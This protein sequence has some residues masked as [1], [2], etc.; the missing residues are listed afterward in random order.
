M[1]K[2]VC[3]KWSKR[4][5]WFVIIATLLISDYIAL[6]VGTGTTYIDNVCVLIWSISMLMMLIRNFLIEYWACKNNN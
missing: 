2:I 3:S 6:F 1:K 5:L 4:L